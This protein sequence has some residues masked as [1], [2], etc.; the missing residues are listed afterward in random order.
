M[1]IGAR[2][3]V[4]AQA[5]TPGYRFGLG[6]AVFVGLGC[7]VLP[8]RRSS[9]ASTGSGG[10]TPASVP[11]IAFQTQGWVMLLGALLVVLLF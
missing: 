3:G 6:S 5:L 10:A 2:A 11:A 7:A 1:G 9:L 8:E 4:F